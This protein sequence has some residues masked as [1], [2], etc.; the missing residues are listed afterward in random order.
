MFSIGL[1]S[2]TSMDGIDAA[3]LQTDG[4]PELLKPLGYTTF[5]YQPPF[6][7]L[8]KAAEY[9]A[10]KCA[11]DLQTARDDY[12]C[13][14][15]EYLHTLHLSE[16]LIHQT[17]TY[18]DTPITLDA[19]IQHSTDL[20]AHAVQICLKK[21]GYKADQIDVVG[22]H[23][24]TLFH[25][26]AQKISVIVGDGERLANQIGITVINDFRSNDIAMSGQGAPFAPIYHY[27]LAKHHQKIPLAVVNC[28]GISNVS[29][30]VSEEES[31]L[32]ALDTGPGNGLI[33]SFVRQRTRGKFHMDVD[34]QYGKQ[35]RVHNDVL[36]A[37]YE[38]SIIK[39]NQNYFLLPPPKS[40]DYGDMKLIPELD[41]L[42]LEDACATLAAFTADSIVQSVVALEKT[43]PQQWVLS[44]GGWSNPNIY[45]QF[46]NRLRAQLG[47]SVQIHKADEMG[48]NSQAMEAQL[49]AYLAVRCLQGK[50][51][52]FPGTTG[53]QE[54]MSGGVICR[55]D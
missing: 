32:M 18:L 12:P 3:L 25:A 39:N 38:K 23:G 15:D 45:H 47:E 53:V 4:T 30:I 24:Q 1:M 41:Q 2:G 50:P 37:L 26:P 55:V 49:F 43:L 14:L 8:L 5:S 13:A 19:V 11:G 33:D 48:W 10:R 17:K 6:K 46:K 51:L 16:D 9:A 31:D 27:A 54:P 28:G 22:Y 21:T 40:L 34:G 44:G 7:L 36:N 20:H 52:S 42:S 35:G 29:L